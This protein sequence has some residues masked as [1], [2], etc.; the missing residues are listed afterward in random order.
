MGVKIWPVQHPRTY[1]ACDATVLPDGRYQFDDGT[2]VDDVRSGWDP[3]PRGGA[4]LSMVTL[5]C[6]IAV[7]YVIIFVI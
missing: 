2:I 6:V 7:I 1:Q 4:I 3:P 5:A